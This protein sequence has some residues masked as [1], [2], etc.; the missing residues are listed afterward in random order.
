MIRGTPIDLSNVP[1][2]LCLR[3]EYEHPVGGRVRPAADVIKLLR[4]VAAAEG[5]HGAIIAKLTQT[6]ANQ[7]SED[8]TYA[9]AYYLR[10]CWQRRHR[11]PLSPSSARVRRLGVLEA[12]VERCPGG[13]AAV[14]AARHQA[15]TED[16]DG[17]SFAARRDRGKFP[18]RIYEQV[19]E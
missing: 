2:R 19:H 10:S 18:D 17:H 4:A 14:A 15:A 13:C 6:S 16:C 5:R 8:C 3:I 12:L 7:F 11:G 1:P 9:Y